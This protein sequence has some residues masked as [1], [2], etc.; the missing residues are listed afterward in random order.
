MIKSLLS[1]LLF[2]LFIFCFELL[3][4]HKELTVE[5]IQTNRD[6]FGKNLSGV[7]WFSGGDKFSFLKRDPAAKA[8]AIYEHDCK[9]GE[10]SFPAKINFHF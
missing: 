7:Q 10:E 5:S 6:F 8:T 2:S 1:T 4:Q 3:P 9:T